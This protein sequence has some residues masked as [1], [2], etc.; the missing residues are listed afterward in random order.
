M[1]AYID[2]FVSGIGRDAHRPDEHRRILLVPGA[3]R[4]RRARST[5]VAVQT[6]AALA[7]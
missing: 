4:P 5:F 7:H 6:H 1:R 2:R 3:G